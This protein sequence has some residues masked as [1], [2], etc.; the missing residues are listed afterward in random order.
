MYIHHRG[1]SMNNNFSNQFLELL[2]R[3]ATNKCQMG[4][5]RSVDL[6]PAPK[7]L[8]KLI[9]HVEQLRRGVKELVIF[10][11]ESSRTT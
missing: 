6:T 11:A 7:E 5:D 9:Q 10:D 8:T 3:R 4:I 1:D 2:T